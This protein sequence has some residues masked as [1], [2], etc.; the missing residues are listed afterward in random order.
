MHLAS[1]ILA[2]I[3]WTIISVFFIIVLGIGFIASYSAGKSSKDF[4]LGGRHMP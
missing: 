1:I 3:D 4:F 2:P